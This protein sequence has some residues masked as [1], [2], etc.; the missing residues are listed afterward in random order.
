MNFNLSANCAFSWPNGKSQYCKLCFI[1]RT[2]AVWIN[3][4][5]AVLVCLPFQQYVSPPWIFH[6]VG[7]LACPFSIAVDVMSEWFMNRRR[8]QQ[9][10]CH[11]ADRLSCGSLTSHE[12]LELD[13]YHVHRTVYIV[14]LPVYHLP[15]F[16]TARTGK[17]SLRR[18]F[19]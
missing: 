10:S 4:G 17:S 11:F 3:T 13:Q 7:S 9:Q 15:P 1:C 5:A 16:T 14:Y 6:C 18:P 12:P 19:S 8:A 2:A